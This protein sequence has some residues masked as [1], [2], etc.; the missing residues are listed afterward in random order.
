MVARRVEPFDSSEPLS[1]TRGTMELRGLSRLLGILLVLGACANHK[2]EAHPVTPGT[3]EAKA[4]P[5]KADDQAPAKPDTKP[6]DKPGD[7]AAAIPGLNLSGLDPSQVAGLN[8]ILDE[9]QS[10]CGKSHSL[11]T[12]LLHDPDCKRSQFAARYLVRVLQAGYLPSEAED[13]YDQRYTSPERGECDTKDAFVRGTAS[14]PVTICEFS[15]FECPHCG[16]AEPLV[17]RLLQDYSGKV[18]LIYKNYPLSAVH[19]EAREAAAAAV[20]AG[21]QG[22]F[23]QMHDKLFANQDR[24]TAA[25][26]ARYA[27]DLGLDV[28][29][30]QADLAA[31]RKRVEADHAEGEKL[32]ITGTPTF[33]INGRKYAGPLRYEE[34]KDWVDEELAK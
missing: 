17:E 15:D 2:S 19:P 23:W 21:T 28:A 11:R 24:L 25:D 14:A 6:D 30:W 29:R 3:S 34:V 32:G 31:A 1:Y 10:A 5:P 27:K 16:K 33:Y 22:K 13:I 7:K 8:R 20:A 4:A 12:S 18:R 9:K 26:L